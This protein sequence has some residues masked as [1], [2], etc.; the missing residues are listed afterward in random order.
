MGSHIISDGSFIVF[1]EV[2]HRIWWVPHYF[3]WGPT[4]CHMRPSHCVPWCPSLYSTGSLIVFHKVS[5]YFLHG[6]SLFS[7][8]SLI[9][10]HG[11]P[12]LFLYG[13]S[14]CSRG[15]HIVFHG[16]PHCVWYGPSLCSMGF[17]IVFHGL[18]HCVW[19]EIYSCADPDSR[20][21]CFYCGVPRLKPAITHRSHS[22]QAIKRTDSAP[23]QTWWSIM[24]LLKLNWRFHTESGFSGECMRKNW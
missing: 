23:C 10:C 5:Y 12:A 20:V 15:P 7:T 2:P 16:V 14:L 3:P 9:M 8:G 24:S 6:L 19:R 17:H 13:I 18:P 4:L 11:A 21:H 1:H 22:G